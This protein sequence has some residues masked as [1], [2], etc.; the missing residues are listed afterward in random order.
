MKAN[1]HLKKQVEYSYPTSTNAKKFGFYNDG[2]YTVELY[3]SL[4]ISTPKALTAFKTKEEAVAFA[5]TLPN[6]WHP[7]YLKYANK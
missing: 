6:E 7:L 3:D 4:Y 5:E 1:N 2:C